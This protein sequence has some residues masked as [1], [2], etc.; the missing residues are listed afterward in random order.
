MNH[1]TPG[2]PVHHQLLEFTQTHVHW[3]S[4]AI[5]PSHPLSSPSPPA[6]NPSQHQSL[7]QTNS[8]S[9][10]NRCVYVCVCVCMYVCVWSSAFSMKK[11]VSYALKGSFISSFPNWMYF[12]YFSYLIVLVG[13]FSGWIDVIQV[14]ICSSLLILEEMLLVFHHWLWWSLCVFHI[15]VLLCWG[16]FLLLVCWMLF[17]MKGYWILSHDFSPSAEMILFVCFFL[18]FFLHLCSSIFICWTILELLE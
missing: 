7:F 15:W 6:L 16:S 12:I 18:H 17:I 13:T 1:S 11:I 8:F 2:L 14:G 9:N 10:S 5:Q 4:D 3:V